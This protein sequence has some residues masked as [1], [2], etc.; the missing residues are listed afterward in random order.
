MQSLKHLTTLL[1]ICSLAQ[2]LKAKPT[3]PNDDEMNLEGMESS[4]EGFAESL[5]EPRVLVGNEERG[6]NLELG[7]FYQG[8]MKLEPEQ[9][10]ALLRNETEQTQVE[11][12]TGLL[13]ENYRWPKNMEGKVVVP[14]LTEGF[15]K[16]LSS[17]HST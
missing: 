10:A 9:L 1:V 4:E 7:K 3:I 15:S 5:I 17:L 13:S 8:D 14:F 2:T 6:K 16:L 11:S 12:R